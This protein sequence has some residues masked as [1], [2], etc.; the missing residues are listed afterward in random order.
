[1]AEGVEEPAQ[2]DVMQRYGC[3][4][5]QGWLAAQP[6]PATQIPA[7]LAHWSA[8]PRPP[9]AAVLATAAM[10]LEAGGRA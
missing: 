6:M 2:A 7:F 1:V 10:P 3:N 4:L 9:A 5:M 8:Q